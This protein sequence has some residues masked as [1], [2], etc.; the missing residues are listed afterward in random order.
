M[1]THSIKDYLP[2]HLI[3]YKGNCPACGKVLGEDDSIFICRECMRKDKEYREQQK[4][5]QEDT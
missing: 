5:V 1:Q 2:P 3:V 4:Q